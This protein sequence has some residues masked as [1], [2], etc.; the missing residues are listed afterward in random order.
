M[1]KSKKDYL[2]E[3]MIGVISL[4]ISVAYFALSYT[5]GRNVS[6]KVQM[7]SIEPTLFPRAIGVVAIIISLTILIPAVLGYIRASSTDTTTT[8]RPKVITKDRLVIVISLIVYLIIMQYIGYI[9]STIIVA[10]VILNYIDKSKWK[11][12]LIYSIFF[13]IVCFF[14][15]NNL[16]SIW[17]PIGTIFE[18]FF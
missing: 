18:A 1:K 13:P 17:L 14:V 10:L 16:L 4:V 11:R 12:N 7:N 2:F 3:S 9:V 8:E 15:F 5:I 6:M